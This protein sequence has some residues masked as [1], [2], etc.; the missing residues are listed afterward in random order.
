MVKE[1]VFAS[2][3]LTHIELGVDKDL[4]AR[5]YDIAKNAQ[6]H[7]DGKAAANTCIEF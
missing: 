7:D 2:A 5:S 6:H 4:D 3:Y 1:E